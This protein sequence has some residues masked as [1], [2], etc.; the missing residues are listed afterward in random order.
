MGGQEWENS[1]LRDSRTVTNET[2][3]SNFKVE[4]ATHETP[5][6]PALPKPT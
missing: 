6:V 4:C 5:L 2:T 1:A 3:C